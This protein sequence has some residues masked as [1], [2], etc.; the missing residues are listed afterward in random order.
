MGNETP[1]TD[2]NIIENVNTT[3]K[4]S[5]GRPKLYAGGYKSVRYSFYK[6]IELEFVV[7]EAWKRL[8][9]ES[10]YK[11]NSAFASHLLDLYRFEQSSL[12]ASNVSGNVSVC[13][14]E[15]RGKRKLG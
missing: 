8:R 6:K 15:S 5:R 7:V 13:L 3:A 1:E 14:G 12:S 9:H 2:K 4:K 11:T 10:Q